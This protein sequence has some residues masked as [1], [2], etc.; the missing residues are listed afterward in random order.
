[1]KLHL[2]AIL[3][4]SFITFACLAIADDA[5]LPLGLIEVEA[6]EGNPVTD[7]KVQLGKRLFFD[8][9]LSRDGTV[10]CSSCHIPEQAFAQ[11]G[12]PVSSGV[13]GRRGR[14]NSP[15]LFNV[16]FAKT[17]FHDG[18]AGSLEEQAWQPIL[19]MDEMGNTSEQVVIDLLSASDD[20][21][22]AFHA[23]FDSNTGPT[24]ATVAQALASYQRTLLSGNSAFDRWN[25]GESEALSTRAHEGYQLFAGQALC[26]QCHPLNSSGAVLL[27]DQQFHN[28]GL[29]ALKPNADQDLGRY[30]FTGEAK[31]RWHYRTPSLRNVALTAPYMHDGSIAT[32]REVVEFYNRAE[33]R[34]EL[35]PLQL[36]EAE[37][38]ALVAF[39]E[40][41]T[42]E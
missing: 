5:E 36:N 8:K 42:S 26:W 38:T 15:S 34:G 32:L 18:R 21:V 35:Q 24:K 22:A 12:H 10:A 33:G 39:L 30:E 3:C 2:N 20:Y 1:M 28:T 25:W 11:R 16:A 14:R 4:G 40:A 13:A 19:A 9:S 6:P 23:A 31:D 41:L 27:T 17:L 7:A 29:A 37:V